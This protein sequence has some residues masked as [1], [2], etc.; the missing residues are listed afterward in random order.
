MAGDKEGYAIYT[1]DISN[2]W[3]QEVDCCGCPKVKKKKHY[4]VSFLLMANDKVCCYMPTLMQVT[5]GTFGGSHVR[6]SK[7]IFFPNC[8]D[9]SPV[10]KQLQNTVPV[11]GLR[12]SADTYETPFSYTSH[13]HS[14]MAGM[15]GSQLHKCLQSCLTAASKQAENHT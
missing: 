9:L 4:P 1:T 11:A 6:G 10:Y 8:E 15:L 12:L 5:D 2:L 7:R 3:W 14:V 13:S